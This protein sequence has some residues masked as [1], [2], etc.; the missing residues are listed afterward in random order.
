MKREREREERER[1]RERWLL[2]KTSR[3]PICDDDVPFYLIIRKQVE[4]N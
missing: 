2:S 3:A 4:G 1:E